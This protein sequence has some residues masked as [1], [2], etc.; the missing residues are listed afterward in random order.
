M[1][2]IGM[3]V[4]MEIDAV[5]LRYGKAEKTE[6]IGTMQVLFYSMEGYEL[7]LIHSGVGELAAAAATQLL[8][9]HYGCELIVN[10][11]VVG[12]LTQEM[13]L[14]K[15]C[16]VTRVVHYDFDISGLDPVEPGRYPQLP[17]VYIPLD[18]ELIE[19]ALKIEP[20][21][22]CVTVASADKFVA[23]EENKKALHEKWDADICEM[24]AAAVALQCWRNRIPC[25]MIKCVSDA[26]QGGG[27]EFYREVLNSSEVCM[28][29]TDKIIRGL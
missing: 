17:D 12:G 20:S 27:D 7:I 3:L 25:L 18:Q 26:I 15:T 24:E 21:L 14:A 19:K 23:G 22:K 16:I 28:G 10:F 11:G 4:A 6:D 1:K 13:T 29:I 5:L 2:K 8:I 9:T